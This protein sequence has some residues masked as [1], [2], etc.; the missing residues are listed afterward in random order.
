MWIAFGY[1]RQGGGGPV[2]LQRCG[3]LS[4]LVFPDGQCQ[5][6]GLRRTGARVAPDPSLRLSPISPDPPDASENSSGQ[7]RASAGSPFWPGRPWFSLRRRL[8]SSSPMRL[9]SR[10]D[11]FSQMGG[12]ILHPDPGRL[13]LWLWPLQVQALSSPIIGA[14]L[15]RP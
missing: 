6:S 5:S 1:L 4:P 12:R 15:D 10:R 7:A 11:L 2:Y 8:C 9:P 3:S 13:K 14:G